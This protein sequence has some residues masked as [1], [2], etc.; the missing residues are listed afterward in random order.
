MNLSVQEFWKS[1]SIWQSYGQKSGVLFFLVHSVYIVTAVVSTLWRTQTNN[2]PWSDYCGWHTDHF[3]W[4]RQDIVEH[5]FD[6][7]FGCILDLQ[8]GYWKISIYLFGTDSYGPRNLSIRWVP[9]SA[10]DGASLERGR[11][12]AVPSH[13]NVLLYKWIVHCLF[14]QHPQ[15]T[16]AIAATRGEN[17]CKSICMT[18]KVAVISNATL[19]VIILDILKN[20]VVYS[21]LRVWHR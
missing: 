5:T 11:A 10:W 20:F 2:L 21:V 1:V 13:C 9:G 12:C 19:F 17:I 3:P 8:I 4:I 16:S 15:R 6:W 14:A 7:L 18:A